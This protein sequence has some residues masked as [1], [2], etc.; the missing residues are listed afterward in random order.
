MNY[1]EL[2]NKY[3]NANPFANSI[4]IHVTTVR[5]G[6]AEGEVEIMPKHGNTIQSL[7][8]GVAYTL[9]DTVTGCASRSRGQTCTT[10]EGKL[11]HI[12]AATSKDKKLIAKGDVLHFGQK[13]IVSSVEITNDQGQMLAAGLF[14]FFALDKKDLKTWV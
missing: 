2:M 13:T 11:N 5:D 9:A 8:G 3:N 6:Y 12:R 7:H 14:T 10:I 4:G 1:E